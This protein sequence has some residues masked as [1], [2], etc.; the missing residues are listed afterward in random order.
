MERLSDA[1]LR[2]LYDK[3]HIFILPS[4]KAKDGFH[5]E[6]QAVVI[7]EAQAS[8]VIVIATNAGGIPE[9]VDDGKSAF[10][11]NDRSADEITEQV[12]ALL[13]ESDSWG[14]IRRAARKWVEEHFCSNV[15]GKRMNDVYVSLL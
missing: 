12:L 14:H 13:S 5:E 9:C 11:V 1:E 7:Q 2:Q 6:T 3:S 15:I 4:L 10:L 8:G